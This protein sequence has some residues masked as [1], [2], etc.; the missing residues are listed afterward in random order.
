MERGRGYSPDTRRNREI[1]RSWKVL[2][3]CRCAAL[4]HYYSASPARRIRS[5]TL[6]SLGPAAGRG[7]RYEMA[8]RSYQTPAT[9][10]ATEETEE[11]MGRTFIAPGV[12]DV[13]RGTE[14]L[15]PC[16]ITCTTRDDTG[17]DNC[18]GKT[19][20]ADIIVT[21]ITHVFSLESPRHVRMS[22]GI[23]NTGSFITESSCSCFLK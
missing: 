9:K 13:V 2:H 10:P 18:R 1:A 11:I 4:R 22:R 5:A 17:R 16:T 21:A 7:S 3:N 6:K 8:R 20:G 19:S 12:K 23:A 15:V 14:R